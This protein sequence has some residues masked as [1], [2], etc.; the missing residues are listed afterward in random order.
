M[1]PGLRFRWDGGLAFAA[2]YLYSK[3]P[4]TQPP[5][6]VTNTPP[7]TETITPVITDT[8][9][10]VPVDIP[11]PKGKIVFTCEVAGDEICI[12][13]ADGSVSLVVGSVDIGGSRTAL[14]R[15]QTLRALI[16]WSYDLLS[17][18]EQKL[19]RRLSVFA[20]GCN[21]ESVEAVCNAKADL[22][23]DLLDGMASLLDKSLLQHGEPFMRWRDWVEVAREEELRDLSDQIYEIFSERLMIGLSLILIPLIAAPLLFQLPASVVIT[24]NTA[25]LVILLIFILEYA[26]KLALAEDRREFFFNPWH[27]LDLFIILAPSVGL[28]VGAGYA[29]G[30]FLRLLRLLRLTQAA[31]LGGRAGNRHLSLATTAHEPPSLQGPPK[32]RLMPLEKDGMKN[33]N[34]AWKPCVLIPKHLGVIM[35][36]TYPYL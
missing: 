36:A 18:E 9:I 27:I 34:C 25:D 22:D 2:R 29:Q 16:D 24:F 10:N 6:T 4:T 13:N 26:F 21:L 1:A 8:A 3:T 28:I 14:P 5:S 17:P 31:S 23:L 7:Y 15:Q 35:T 11:K 33:A 12:I 30:R 20:G 19:F 32:I